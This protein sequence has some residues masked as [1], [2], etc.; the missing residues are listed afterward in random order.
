MLLQIGR[1][2]FGA[3]RS[4][5]DHPFHTI[6][7]PHNLDRRVRGPLPFYALVAVIKHIDQSLELRTLPV[8]EKYTPPA[9]GID[10][11]G[12]CDLRRG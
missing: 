7:H 3:Q 8:E 5:V 12:T 11:R 9:C 4:I 2:I 6:L 1:R 10:L